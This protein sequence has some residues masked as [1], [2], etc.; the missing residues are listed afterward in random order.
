ML[1]L[2]SG[3]KFLTRCDKFR[4][5]GNNVL[6][7]PDLLII[8]SSLAFLA[9]CSDWGRLKTHSCSHFAALTSLGLPLM[10]W[11]CQLTILT[12]QWGGIAVPLHTAPVVQIAISYFIQQFDFLP[13]IDSP[14]GYISLHCWLS[15][16]RNRPIICICWASLSTS[17]PS[18]CF[19]PVSRHWTVVSCPAFINKPP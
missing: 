5:Q 8:T 10:F 19:A 13:N 6:T 18:F 14:G 9:D 16:I 4:V 2:E 15:V 1:H 7:W 11:C 17:Q 3:G 12:G